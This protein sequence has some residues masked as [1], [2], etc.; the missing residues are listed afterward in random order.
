VIAALGSHDGAFAALPVVDALWSSSGELAQSP[1]P[2]DGLWRAQTPQ[3]FD[4]AKILQAHQSHDGSGA[5]DV[6][7]AR[8]AGLNVRLIPGSEA[9]YKITTAA[10]LDRAIRDVGAAPS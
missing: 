9:N 3:G 1:V 5:D 7:V 2:R 8:D 4:F 6:A 10:D